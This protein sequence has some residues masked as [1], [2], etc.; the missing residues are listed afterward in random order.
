MALNRWCASSVKF[1]IQNA[2]A[3]ENRVPLGRCCLL[4]SID[5]SL[6]KQLL[7]RP[8]PDRGQ[9]VPTPP[10]RP[11]PTNW[12]WLTRENRAFS[13]WLNIILYRDRAFP[14]LN[15]P[16]NLLLWL[17]AVILSDPLETKGFLRIFRKGGHREREA[18]PPNSDGDC[19][20]LKRILTKVG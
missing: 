14:I 15:Q 4:D 19:N 12:S 8:F 10:Y 18:Q 13:S 3:L 20:H 2:A 7:D 6:R 16:E 9:K 11:T 1:A 17:I 5:G